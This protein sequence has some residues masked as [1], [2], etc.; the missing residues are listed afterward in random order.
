VAIVL[1]VVVTIF[2]TTDAEIVTTRRGRRANDPR[3]KDVFA[4]GADGATRPHEHRA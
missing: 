4:T 1:A 2:V 3:G